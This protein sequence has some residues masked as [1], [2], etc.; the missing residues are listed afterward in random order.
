MSSGVSSP[1]ERGGGRRA[2]VRAL[3]LVLRSRLG[4]RGFCPSSKHIHRCHERFERVQIT[5][6]A[7]RRDD[8]PSVTFQQ[9]LKQGDTLDSPAGMIRRSD[10]LPGGGE[11][12]GS[13]Y[14]NTEIENPGE[15]G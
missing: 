1:G 8:Y 3:G 11:V 9:Q 5:Q 6:D 13:D 7:I 10:E 14:L 15:I 4:R 12:F 2:W